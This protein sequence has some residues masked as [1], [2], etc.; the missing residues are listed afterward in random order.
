MTDDQIK[1]M[2]K[3]F[4]SWQLPAD[5]SPDGGISFTPALGAP[6]GTN[7]FTA[8][9]ADAMVRHMLGC[10]DCDPTKAALDQA[11]EEGRLEVAGM[12]AALLKEM[13]D[14]WDMGAPS[15]PK[16]GKLIIAARGDIPRYRADTAALAAIQKLAREKAP[17]EDT[18]PLAQHNQRVT[19]LL[20]ANN[21]EVER[22]RQAEAEACRY[23]MMAAEQDAR[24]L[25]Q[26]IALMIA[27]KWGIAT[28]GCWDGEIAGLL[29]D[30]IDRGEATPI[31]WPTNPFVQKWLRE[32]GLD[33]CDGAIG[34]PLVVTLAEANG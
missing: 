13:H 24:I 2:V 4:L 5:F 7:L 34:Y 19:E 31:P 26:R 3:Q 21:A 11:R 25:R 8:T 30:W 23:R 16:L 10:L 14:L 12:I 33:D 15:D 32:Q 27:R 1:A 18:V 20:L 17:I 6:V 22:R 28:G 9:Q 29:G